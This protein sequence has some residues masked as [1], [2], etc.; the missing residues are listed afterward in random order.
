[1][2]QEIAGIVQRGVAQELK[3]YLQRV[4]APLSSAGKRQQNQQTMLSHYVR[5]R[6]AHES[7]KKLCLSTLA[8]DTGASKGKLR[9]NLWNGFIA[10]K[11]LFERDLIRKPAA[12][13]WFKL[14]W[15]LVWQRKRLM[16]LVQPRGIYCFYSREL[17]GELTKLIAGRSCLE[18][19]AGDGTLT[20]FL[21]NQGVE[22]IATDN[23]G[24]SKA[25]KYPEWVIKMDAREALGK[26]APEVVICSWPPA[27]NDFEKFVFSTPSVQL[28]IV[29]GSRHTF[30][31][32]NWKDYKLQS[33]FTLEEDKKL[34]KLLL[35]PE[36]ESAVYIFKRKP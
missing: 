3:D 8:A 14:F 13:F 32:G 24:W 21:N 19:G 26:Y 12:L 36:L 25:V 4:A 15:P 9:F 34:A 33:K 5:S 22:I 29:I 27:Q 10:Q 35:P 11:L 2:Q 7:V 31:F 18:I 23:Y 1:M 17:I 16:S 30:A 28:Y 20:K 6:I